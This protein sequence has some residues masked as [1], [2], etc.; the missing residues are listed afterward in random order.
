MARRLSPPSSRGTTA[1]IAAQPRPDC[2]PLCS[3]APRPPAR[4]AP[5]ERHGPEHR[6]MNTP[7]PAPRTRHRQPP[8]RQIRSVEQHLNPTPRKCLG[9]RTHPSRSHDDRLRGC[10]RDRLDDHV[11]P[12]LRP[13]SARPC[14]LIALSSACHF[15]KP[16]SRSLI[17]CPWLFCHSL[18][19]Q[20]ALLAPIGQTPGSNWAAPDTKS[21]T[22]AG[23]ASVLVSPSWSG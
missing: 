23:S 15:E 4:F 12:A 14:Q 21:S 20:T 6:Q 17:F 9:Y 3:Q 11:G 8:D 2:R 19:A 10:Q 1:A 22:T 13:E 18:G 16:S 5:A 7:P